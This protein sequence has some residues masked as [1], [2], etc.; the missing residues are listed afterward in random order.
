MLIFVPGTMN[1]PTDP[2]GS[3]DQKQKD[4]VIPYSCKH[5]ESRRWPC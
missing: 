5:Q 2:A 4:Y 3:G 1:V